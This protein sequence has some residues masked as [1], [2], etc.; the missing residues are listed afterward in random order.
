MLC[1]VPAISYYR[2]KKK[3]AYH[4]AGLIHDWLENNIRWAIYVSNHSWQLS[5][6]PATNEFEVSLETMISFCL[7]KARAV[8]SLFIKQLEIP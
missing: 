6:L 3:E 5:V 4:S 1:Q 7:W 8:I 2:L